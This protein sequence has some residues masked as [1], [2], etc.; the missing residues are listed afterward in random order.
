MQTY[1][2]LIDHNAARCN[3]RRNGLATAG[4]EVISAVEEAEAAEALKSNRVDV[5]CID[6]QFV[7]NCESGIGASLRA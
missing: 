5:V 7:T 1:V 3:E 4:V 2:L 6:T